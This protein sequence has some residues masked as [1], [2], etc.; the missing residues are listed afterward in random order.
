MAKDAGASRTWKTSTSGLR[1]SSRVYKVSLSFV[2]SR[3]RAF[4]ILLSRSRPFV[5][6]R[7]DPPRASEVAAKSSC[8]VVLRRVGRA[9]SRHFDTAEAAELK[10]RQVSL[11]EG[12]GMNH[13]S[14][15]VVG[16]VVRRGDARMFAACEP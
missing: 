16:F 13:L 3:G 15:V 10:V 4:S 14:L 1:E 5:L 2:L 12:D 8:R 9:A 7:A 6:I 11:V